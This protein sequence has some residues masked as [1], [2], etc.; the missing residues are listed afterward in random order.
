[1]KYYE[2][3][4][5]LQ[6]KFKNQYLPFLPR[7]LTIFIDNNLGYLHMYMASEVNCNDMVKYIIE[8]FDISND[9]SDARIVKLSLQYVK[10][11]FHIE[12]PVYIQLS[13]FDDGSILC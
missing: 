11:T 2:I 3:E 5:D 9:Y 6:R 4:E 7:L 12:K 8:H 1:M 13:I 10:K